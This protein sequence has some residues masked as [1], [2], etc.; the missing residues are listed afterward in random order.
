MKL[1]KILIICFLI[2]SIVPALIVGLLSYRIAEDELYKQGRQDLEERVVAVKHIMEVLDREVSAGNIK[3]DA[4]MELVR[5]LV[6]GDKLPEGGRDYMN[7]FHKGKTGFIWFM[8]SKGNAIGDIYKKT[9][10]VNLYEY[11][12]NDPYITKALDEKISNKHGWYESTFIDPSTQQK[13]NNTCSYDYYPSRDIIIGAVAYLNEFTAPVK[14]VRD[15]TF[16]ICFITIVIVSL[17]SLIF[18]K[19]ISTPLVKLTAFTTEIGKGNLEV[20]IPAFGLYKELKQLTNSFSTMAIKLKEMISANERNIDKLKESNEFNQ[21]LIENSPA[22]VWMSDENGRCSFINKEFTRLLGY[23]ADELIGL[24]VP[25]FPY[26]C[27]S[28]L[29][30]MEAGTLKVLEKIW[31]RIIE[32]RKSAKGDVPFITKGGD[33]VIHQGIEIPYG[34]GEGRLWASLDITEMKRYEIELA[35]TVNVF[36]FALSKAAEGDLSL[37]VDLNTISE[38]YRGIGRNINEM[39]SSTKKSIDELQKREKELAKTKG[40]Y[41]ELVELSKGI[42]LRWKS[43]GT[44]T[45]W[46]KFAQE[47]FGYHMNEIIGQNVMNTIVPQSESTGRDLNE[48][49]DNI[50][51]NPKKYPTNI[52]ENVRKNGEHVWISWSNSFFTNE[53]G[54]NE[55]ISIGQDITELRRYEEKLKKTNEFNQLLL[56]NTPAS[57]WILDKDG[58]CTY[59]NSE[60]VR[61]SGWS[62]EKLIGLKIQESPHIC[63]SGLPYMKEGTMDILIPYLKNIRENK[64]SYRITLPIKKN[65]GAIMLG[66]G[67][68]VPLDDELSTIWAGIDITEIIKKEIEL[69][70]LN[71]QL[72]EVSHAKSDFLAS[73][74]HE[75]RTPLNAIIGF[76]EILKDGLAG[77]LAEDQ[78]EYITDIFVSGHHLLSLIN[79]ILDLSKV[80]AGKMELELEKTDL[81]ELL[82]DSLIIIK[83]KSQ[84]H[85]INLISDINESLGE[86]MVDIRKLKQ[87]VYNLLSNAVK[88][89]PDDGNITL[90]ANITTLEEL[91][92]NREKAGFT[93]NIEPLSKYSNYIK[94]DV[95][96]TGIGIEEDDMNKLFEAFTQVGT[97]KDKKHKGT[98]LGLAL[99]QQ[100]A[101][102]HGGTVSVNSRIGQGSTFTIWIPLITDN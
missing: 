93:E 76:S 50:R 34:K 5:T 67:I 98:G 58:I 55:I 26:F 64:R 83:E 87:I 99:V 72:K 65:T 4:Y 60:F 77:E 62:K 31:Q 18:S 29:P 56:E 32:E 69:A 82:E 17:F 13:Y 11:F 81:K 94:I 68:I 80:E 86:P 39:I 61:E 95:E 28:G 22:A 44:I 66:Y 59:V 51:K 92:I 97:D 70:N 52:N 15:L 74:S 101:E 57:I 3:E 35:N 96:D 42:I 30:Y 21:A 14:N 91:L 45:F 27:K 41:S 33:I 8:D 6:L 48:M 2:S 46:N 49:I 16:I 9:E 85:M 47:F 19:M 37:K 24:K 89:T 78:K 84:K 38:Q 1:K 40:L 102:L 75:L 73:M 10:G 79:D 36:G 7:A 100:Y 25:D 23:T 90:S 88:F 71:T 12:N 20:R 43:D 54:K 53:E 63:K